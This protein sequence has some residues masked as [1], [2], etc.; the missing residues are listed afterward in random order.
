MN[1][2]LNL[3]IVISNILIVSEFETAMNME[4]LVINASA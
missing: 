2:Y 3:Y 1:T 4:T